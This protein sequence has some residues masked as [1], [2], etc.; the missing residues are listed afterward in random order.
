MIKNKLFTFI[1]VLSLISAVCV[2][3]GAASG[4][5][6]TVNEPAIA[7]DGSGYVISGTV[8]NIRAN[9]SVTLEIKNS[10]TGKICYVDQ[11]ITESGNTFEFKKV[12]LHPKNDSGVYTIILSAENGA[13]NDTKS[14]A[15]HGASEQVDALEAITSAG[16][17]AAV[18]AV[19]SN[20]TYAAALGIDSALYSGMGENGKNVIDGYF[21]A[22]SYTTPDNVTD[23]SNIDILVKSMEA[24]SADWADALCAAEFADISDTAGLNK[25]LTD[26]LPLYS[27]DN[28]DTALIKEDVMYNLV[29]DTF[30]EAKFLTRISAI[31][32]ASSSADAVDKLLEA[33]ALTVIE[34]H[35][36][37]EVKKLY[38]TFPGLFGIDTSA[39]SDVSESNLGALY[40]ASKGSYS[41]Y[42]DAGEGFNALIGDYVGGTGGGSGGGRGN[43]GG[44]GSITA[45]PPS[46]SEAS[47]KLPFPDMGN[48]A[49]AVDAVTALKEKGIVSGDNSGNFNPNNYITRA[50]F[51]KMVVL[52][53]DL[54][55][56]VE[57]DEFTDV[58]PGMWYYPYVKAARA[59]GIVTGDNNNRFR[60]DDLISREDMTVILYRARGD[61]FNG[62]DG[63]SF[64]DSDGI[65]DYARDAVAQFSKMGIVNGIG[66]NMFAPKNNATRAQAA[67]II[68]NAFVK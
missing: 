11:L 25:W 21:A 4:S 39:L 55:L 6:M 15:F 52:A 49:W 5:V 2:P 37:T 29:K 58:V 65:S 16:S 63:I 20:P 43:G 34:S 19:M 14:L 60:P 24:F 33:G 44:G 54:P 1:L 59:H 51:I 68:Y 40:E 23:D 28:A 3:V 64:A 57:A 42:V 12:K 18:K 7:S 45:P 41:S 30:T 61:K 26:Y 36:Y 35:H 53:I 50:E 38:D 13:S 67:Q 62:T 17:A 56:S 46:A 66:G 8:S 22:K 27:A 32:S 9:F 48:A 31:T 47:P 10:L